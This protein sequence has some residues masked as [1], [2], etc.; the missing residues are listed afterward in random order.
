MTAHEAKRKAMKALHDATFCNTEITTHIGIVHDKGHDEPCFITMDAMP[1]RQTTLEY[2]K[3][4]GIESLFS[5]F[6]SQGFGI[7]NTHIKIPER[8]EKLVMILAFALYWATSTGMWCHTQKPPKGTAKKT[9]ITP[10]L[11]TVGMRFFRNITNIPPPLW[12][13]WIN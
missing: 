4:W 12:A 9:P 6:K 13:M 11:F 1:S 2:G 5:D 3:R 7:T 8:L 10:I